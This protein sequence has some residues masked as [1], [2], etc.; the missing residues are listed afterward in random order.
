MAK[1]RGSHSWRDT[2]TSRGSAG[3]RRDPQ[4]SEIWEN[5]PGIPPTTREAREA[6]YIYTYPFKERLPCPVAVVATPIVSDTDNF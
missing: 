3:T 4:G 6:P 5:V 2:L 1:E